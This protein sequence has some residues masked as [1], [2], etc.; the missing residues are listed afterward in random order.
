MLSKAGYGSIKELRELDTH[1]FLN[2]I[3]FE[4]IQN[5]IQTHLMDEAKNKR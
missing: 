3:E 4:N 2:L 1:E 5:D